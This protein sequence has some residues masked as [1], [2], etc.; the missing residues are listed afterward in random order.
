AEHAKFQGTKVTVASF[1]EWKEN[2]ER[3]M[4]EKERNTKSLA[5]L[6]KEEMRKN[7]LTGRQL[8][9]HDQALAKS[10]VTFM[11]EDD[12]AV[13]ISIFEREVDMESEEEENDV[14]DL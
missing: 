13:D 4:A 12:V 6:K 7:K 10:D 11:D 1:L 3:E 2:I 5:L 9:E 14:L 8:F